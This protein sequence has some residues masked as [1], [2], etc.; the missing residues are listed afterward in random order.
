M[1]KAHNKITKIK[2]KTENIKALQSYYFL[3]SYYFSHW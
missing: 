3:K 2:L 1:K